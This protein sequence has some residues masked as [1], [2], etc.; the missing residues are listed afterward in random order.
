MALN[1]TVTKVYNPTGRDMGAPTV[2]TVIASGD[3]ATT[4]ADPGLLFGLLPQ[5][6]AQ[7]WKSP[8][9]ALYYKKKVGDEEWWVNHTNQHD[10]FQMEANEEKRVQY[11]GGGG[12]NKNKKPK[13][14]KPGSGSI[15]D[16]TPKKGKKI[17][18]TGDGSNGLLGLPPG[19]KEWSPTT[20]DPNTG[21]VQVLNPLADPSN[22]YIN[23]PSIKIPRSWNQRYVAKGLI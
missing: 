2:G 14:K 6:E 12:D 20:I 11:D 13:K 4:N 1:S 15:V 22:F 7:S 10:R 16:T 21:K 9:G 5:R 18:G 17:P 19:S 8:T 23:L 3:I